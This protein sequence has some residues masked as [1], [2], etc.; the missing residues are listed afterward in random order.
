MTELR[1]ATYNIRKA[2]GTDRRRDP[3]RVLRVIDAL[4][5]EVVA[6]QEADLRLPPRRPALD[7]MEILQ[8]TGLRPVE[9]SHGRESLGWHGNALLVSPE[10]EVEE[11]GHHDLRSL[12]PRGLVEAVLSKEGRRFRVFAI[13][14]ALARVVRRAQLSH[15]GD[16]LAASAEELPT[17]VMG[18]FNERSTSV[19]LGRLAKRFTILAEAPTYHSRRPMFSLDRI[20]HTGQFRTREVKAVATPESRLA[21][22]HLP[23]T[24]ELSLAR[25]VGQARQDASGRLSFK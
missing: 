25:E 10:I 7:R 3:G 12:E 18:D 24:A 9:F 19:G 4:K 13:H 5:A 23:L 21:S 2:L 20:A 22:D 6:L 14:L 8:R 17:L 16:I 1:V 11:R 15:L